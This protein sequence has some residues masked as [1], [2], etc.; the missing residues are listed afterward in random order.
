MKLLRL[1]LGWREVEVELVPSQHDGLV[2]DDG[3]ARGW[4]G[5]AFAQISRPSHGFGDVEEVVQDGSERWLLG[6]G[7]RLHPRV[8]AEA[9]TSV[10]RDMRILLA[11]ERSCR[12]VV[13]GVRYDGWTEELEGADEHYLKMVAFGS[14]R[15]PRL[16]PYFELG[17]W[18]FGRAIDDRVA[19]LA[20]SF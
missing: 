2:V 14:R 20:R 11:R 15:D 3:V 1:D 7:S 9:T 6:A 19:Y 12:G 4:M 18:T 16:S 10:V 5:A 13:V 17:F 8:S